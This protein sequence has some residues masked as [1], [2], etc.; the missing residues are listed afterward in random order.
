M[1]HTEKILAP[2]SRKGQG[3]RQIYLLIIFALALPVAVL[4]PYSTA[5]AALFIP[6][7]YRM[8]DEKAVKR[9]KM[10]EVVRREL[11]MPNFL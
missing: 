2:A 5:F 6:F 1:T 8:G 3:N 11:G 7:A 9:K 4:S 10:P